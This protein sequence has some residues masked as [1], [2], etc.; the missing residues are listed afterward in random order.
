[1]YK[2]FYGDENEALRAAIE[3][4]KGYKA[5]AAYLYPSLKPDTAYARVKACV[6]DEKDAKFSLGEIIALCNFN[7]R[8]DP[9]MYS[10]DETHHD[11]PTARAPEDME[12]QLMREY[13]NAV[14]KQSRLADRMERLMAHRKPA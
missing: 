13:I 4:G 5:T 7:G 6:N 2:L 10:A 3:N 8:F 9:F 14:E 12:A 1:M 11:R